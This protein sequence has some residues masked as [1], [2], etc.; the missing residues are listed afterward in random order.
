MVG[1]VSGLVKIIALLIMLY[2]PLCAYADGS[3]VGNMQDG[4]IICGNSGMEVYLLCRKTD[5]SR[6][7]DKGTAFLK[8]RIKNKDFV[9]SCKS[10][11]IPPCPVHQSGKLFAA[12]FLTDALKDNLSAQEADYISTLI[13]GEKRKN[14]VWG[15]A[16]FG[17]PDS[18]DTAFAMRTLRM[19]GNDCPLH[20]LLA[21]YIEEQGG[22]VTFSIKKKAKLANKINEAN[23]LEM[24]PEVNAN[25]FWLFLEDNRQPA[26]KPNLDLIYESQ[27]ADGWFYSYFYPG[28]YYGTYMALTLICGFG[29]KKEAIDRGIRFLSDSQ[30]P[31]GSWGSPSSPYETA[32]ALNAIRSCTN[33][34]DPMEF[35]KGISYL[36]SKQQPD[37]SWHTDSI[38]WKYLVSDATGV[39][40]NAYD[41]NNAVTTSLVVNALKGARQ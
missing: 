39:L 33:K 16:A 27:A 12:F 2:V 24:H 19:L 4:D 22:F 37:G 38:I 5:I 28:K 9:L 26:V 8:E 20:P 18:D 31:D 32:L 35:T 21:Y 40:W 15:Y 17:P 36:L 1:K 29:G 41:A 13:L 10:T 30:N 23:N 3:P 25:V 34:I 11:G 7:I 14:G 6:A